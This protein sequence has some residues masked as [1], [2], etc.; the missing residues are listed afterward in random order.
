MLSPQSR[1][2]SPNTTYFIPTDD[3]FLLGV[4]NSKSIWSYAKER[5]SVMGDAEERGRLR[6]FTQFVKN[7]PIPQAT[8][9]EKLEIEKL[10][11][12]CIPR[13]GRTS[14]RRRSE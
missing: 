4:L 11:Q 14:H 5:L 13:M 2:I 3:L 12:I 1:C 6:F 7:I 10:V 9:K 8:P